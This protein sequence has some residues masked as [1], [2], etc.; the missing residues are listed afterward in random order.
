MVTRRLSF[1]FLL[2]LKM[3]LFPRLRISRRRVTRRRPFW[4][5]FRTLLDGRRTRLRRRRP[6]SLVSRVVLY[7]KLL[8]LVFIPRRRFLMRHSRLLVKVFVLWR[9]ILFR[10]RLILILLLLG[11]LVGLELVTIVMMMMGLLLL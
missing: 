7:R 11:R 4:L 10:W 9:W 3:R 1:R 6:L 2:I 8:L 5:I